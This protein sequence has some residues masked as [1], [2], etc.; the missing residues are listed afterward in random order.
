MLLIYVYLTLYNYNYA[1]SFYNVVIAPFMNIFSELVTNIDNEVASH[2]RK[3]NL[4]KAMEYQ[5][6][7]NP[8]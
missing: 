1:E 8:N 2:K 3:L 6:D 7:K 4:I 5:K